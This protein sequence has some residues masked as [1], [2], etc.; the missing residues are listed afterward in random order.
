[1]GHFLTRDDYYC[2]D[3]SSEELFSRAMCTEF[4]EFGT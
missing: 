3:L 1:M 2:L 4:R